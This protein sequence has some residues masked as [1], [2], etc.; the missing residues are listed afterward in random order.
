MMAHRKQGPPIGDK[1]AMLRHLAERFN[2]TVSWMILNLIN[3]V[4]AWRH[5]VSKTRQCSQSA[6]FFCAQNW[7]QLFLPLHPSSKGS[8]MKWRVFCA[9][10]SLVWDERHREW[11]IADSFINSLHQWQTLKKVKLALK[12]VS[13]STWPDPSFCFSSFLANLK[14]PVFTFLVFFNIWKCL[15]LLF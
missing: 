3:R 13:L 6:V 7:C 8:S 1:R 5:G 15:F 12:L 4:I 14:N 9:T 11:N 10:K 2:K